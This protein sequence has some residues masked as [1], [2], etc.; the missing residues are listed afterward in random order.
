MYIYIYIYIDIVIFTQVCLLYSYPCV[1]CPWGTKAP[2]K[3]TT[4]GWA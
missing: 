3:V 2:S 1:F 4:Y